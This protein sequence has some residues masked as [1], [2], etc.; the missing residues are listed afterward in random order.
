MD[1]H[2]CDLCNESVP[3]SD[4]A[5]GKA[6]RRKGRVV[7]ARCDVAM[8]GHG[9]DDAAPYSGSAGA[10]VPTQTMAPPARSGLAAA[11][12]RPP[13]TARMDPRS[14]A[15]APGGQFDSVGDR[16]GGTRAW[17]GILGLMLGTAALAAVGVGGVLVLERLDGIQS[18]SGSLRGEVRSATS[19]L[20][21]ERETALAPLMGAIDQAS[22][23]GISA[24][25]EQ[26]AV[27]ERRIQQLEVQLANQAARESEI[28]MSLEAVRLLVDQAKS[29]LEE[30]RKMDQQLIAKLDNVV[31]FH[32][33]RIIEL[34][35]KIREAGALV[36]AGLVPPGAAGTP[37][38]GA[39]PAWEALLPQL[40]SADAAERLDAAYE[41]GETRDQ[42]VIPH[43][44]PL[45][46]DED[47]FVRMVAAQALDGLGAKLAVPSLIKC[48]SDETITVR[49]AAL[50][51]LRNITGQSFGYE[52]DA[53]EADRKRKISQWSTWWSRSGD[54]FLAGK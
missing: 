6:F 19:S 33:D 10:G 31:Q 12:K 41:L 24:A 26:A 4:F 7:C 37:D 45:L 36:A 48:L 8:G 54:D 30:D 46:E 21:S 14:V 47:V 51:A 52:P 27:A 49:E 17:P 38:P 18:E 9:N 32:G 2:F 13:E 15:M 43:L 16:A 34:E 11:A 5:L 23:R 20:R 35:E 29:G 28:R 22:E 42:G 25:K 44:I 1:I 3:A 40:T 39:A 53:R 50:I